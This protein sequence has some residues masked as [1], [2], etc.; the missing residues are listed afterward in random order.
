MVKNKKFKKLYNFFKGRSVLI[1]GGTGSLGNELIDIFLND[2]KLKKLVVF[3]RDELKQSDLQKRISEKD[4]DDILRF[5]IGDVRDLDRLKFA[6]RN[7]DY[8]I[9]AAALKHVDLAEYNPLEFIKTNIQGAKSVIEA[10]FANNIKKVIALSTDKAANPINLYGATKLVSDKLFTSANNISGTQTTR[11]SVVRYGN[12]VSSRGSVVPFFLNIKNKKLKYFPVTD[13]EM[14]RFWITLNQSANFVLDSFIRMYGGEIFVPKI[15]S[16]RITDLAKAI[17]PKMKI[18]IT[19]IRPGEKISEILCSKDEF[20]NTLE[21]SDHYV[22]KPSIKFVDINIDYKKNN[23][24]QKGKYVSRNFEYSSSK[25][26]DFLSIKELKS[27][28]TNFEKTK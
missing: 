15:P 5:F 26:N 4:N 20:F 27:F 7:I 14:T 17:D 24:G 25:N 9:H 16:I 3:S 23:L 11:F 1:T 28:I 12:V 18:K 21:F 22:I 2:F 19:G 8:I 10:A 6:T 13:N